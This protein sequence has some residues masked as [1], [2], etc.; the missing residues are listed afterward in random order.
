[1]MTQPATTQP[2]NIQFNQEFSPAR[3]VFGTAFFGCAGAVV[4]GLFTTTS[5]LGGAIFGVS[6][7]LSFRLIHWICDKISCYPDSI[8]FKVAQL[9]LSVIGGIAASALITTAIGFPMTVMTGALLIVTSIGVTIAALLVLGSC[10]CSSALATGIAL[11]TDNRGTL[12][13][14]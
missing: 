6:S 3:M 14:V 4:A 5:P 1:M 13:R 8:I 9:S 2:I 7:L 10:F 12:I 11:G